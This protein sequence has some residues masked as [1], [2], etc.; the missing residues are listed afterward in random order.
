MASAAKRSQASPHA[1]TIAKFTPRD[2]SELNTG[3]GGT[4]PGDDIQ[5][6]HRVPGDDIQP[7]HRVPRLT[8]DQVAQF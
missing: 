3:T 8:P 6:A 4:M 2:R 7:A 5:P 1:A